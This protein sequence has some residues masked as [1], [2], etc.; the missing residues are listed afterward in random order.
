MSEEQ[1]T[2]GETTQQQCLRD[3]RKHQASGGTRVPSGLGAPT[4]PANG[5]RR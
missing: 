5:G 2:P 3:Y 4:V 1:S